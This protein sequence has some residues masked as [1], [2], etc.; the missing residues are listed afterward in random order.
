MGCTSSVPAASAAA[1]DPA[2]MTTST[3]NNQKK[4]G[5]SAVTTTVTTK[6]STSHHI[7]SG[8][9]E[10]SKQQQQQTGAVVIPTKDTSKGGMAH[11]VAAFS[12][13]RIRTR[14]CAFTVSVPVVILPRCFLVIFDSCAASACVLNSFIWVKNPGSTPVA[15]PSGTLNK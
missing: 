13:A 10:A 14:R 7:N 1:G 6:S 15:A 4:D 11:S 8:V 9:E 5:T 3:T 12:C 2:G